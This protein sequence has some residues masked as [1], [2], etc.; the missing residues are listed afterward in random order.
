MSKKE[1]LIKLAII[2]LIFFIGF[3]IRVDSTHLNGVPSDEKAFYEDQNGLP[4]M[5]D[6]DSYYN[7]RVTKNYLN[8][9]YLGDAVINGTEWD[10]HS[11]YPGVPM[12]YPPLIVYTTAL[13]YKLTNL[14]ANIPLLTI[15]FWLPAFIAPLCGIP[16]YFIAS[17]L[18]N[19]YGGIAA[20]ILAVTSPLYFVRSVPGWFDTDMFNVLFP[21]LIILFF[22][23]AFKSDNIR[24]RT[25]FTGLSVF[26]MLFFAMAWDG[27]QY[28]F[29]IISIFCVSYMIWMKIK[30]KNIKKIAFISG[31]FILSSIILIYVLTGILNVINLISGVFELVKITGNQGAWAPWP[32]AYIFIT[33]LQPP[34]L[35]DAIGGIGFFIS[36]LAISGIFL[37]FKILRNKKLKEHFL[38]KMNWFFYSFLIVWT[39]I[40]IFSLKEGIRFVLLL[41]PPLVILAGITVG[42]IKEYFNSLNKKQL[43]NILSLSVLIL[44]TAFSILSVYTTSTELVP[45]MNDN[46]WDTAVWINNNTSNDTVVISSWV[47][48]HFFS[49]IADRPVVFDGRLGYIETLPVRNYDNAYVFGSASPSVAREY[50][51]DKALSTSDANLSFG[52]FRMLATS[53]DLA[54]LT[55]D[56]YTRNTTKSVEILNNILSTDKKTA[57]SMLVN[58]YNLSQNQ[59]ET[60]LKYTHPSKSKPFVIVTYD[61]L[62]YEGYWIFNFG[63]WDFKNDKSPD[64]FYSF[65]KISENDNILKTDDG[66]VMNLKTQSIRW[67][68]KTPYCAIIIKENKIKRMYLSKNSEFCVILNLDD[69]NSAILNKRFENSIFTKLVLEKSNVKNIKRIYKN[70]DVNVWEFNS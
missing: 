38:N 25:I 54:W 53:G 4:Y 67:D 43:N 15:C 30:N 31:I 13:V 32:N 66:V 8:H 42:I 14:F 3:S 48:G 24:T 36:L 70:N 39:V 17:R 59:A 2:L 27:W 19:D 46:L 68:N 37:I 29:Y 35:K 52:I 58:K 18:T 34:S 9:G 51:F 23:E 21:L 40:G 16:A 20:G 44:I 1:Y 12:D 6:M 47:Y 60:I 65:G 63:E 57:S 56:N 26:S 62:I 28:L 5:Y 41:I 22:F 50:W 11:Y 45:R 7:Y 64:H 55:L 61:K 49:G 33:E 10:L 69:K